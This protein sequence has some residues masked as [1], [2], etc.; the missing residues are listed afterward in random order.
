MMLSNALWLWSTIS[1]LYPRSCVPNWGNLLFYQF[2]FLIG[3]WAQPCLRIVSKLILHSKY[4]N[5]HT[6]SSFTMSLNLSLISLTAFCNWILAFPYIFSYNR[7]WAYFPLWI[8]IT[9]GLLHIS[10]IYFSLRF[11]SKCFTYLVTFPLRV[12]LNAS[13]WSLVYSITLEVF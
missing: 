12:S 8:I 11:S 3:K 4:H 1:L 6:F 7:S 5:L 13:Y 10:S 9:S 2:V